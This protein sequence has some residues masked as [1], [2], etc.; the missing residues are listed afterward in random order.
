[1]KKKQT[2]TTKKKSRINK[3]KLS[4]KEATLLRDL[5]PLVLALLVLDTRDISSDTDF[6]DVWLRIAY[7]MKNQLTDFDVRDCLKRSEKILNFIQNNYE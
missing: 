2:K 5:I 4:Y 7:E 1:M 3:P 6:G